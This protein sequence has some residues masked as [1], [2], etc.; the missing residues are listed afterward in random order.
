VERSTR[1]SRTA[2]AD[3]VEAL[4]ERLLR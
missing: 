4:V 1:F 3:R 2:F